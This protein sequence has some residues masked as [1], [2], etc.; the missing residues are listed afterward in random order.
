MGQ[1]IIP[2]ENCE[3]RPAEWADDDGLF[4]EPKPIVL[5]GQEA[6]DFAD[7]VLTRKPRRSEVLAKAFERYR[8]TVISE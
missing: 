8:K 3:K 5:T 7:M 2:T 6:I 4:V 1:S